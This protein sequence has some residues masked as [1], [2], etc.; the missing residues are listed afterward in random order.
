M[1]KDK[2]YSRI[3]TWF[4]DIMFTVFTQH[5]FIINTKDKILSSMNIITGKFEFK[6]HSLFKGGLTVLSSAKPNNCIA[7]WTRIH[8]LLFKKP[9]SNYLSI[10]IF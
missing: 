8:Y 3:K 1:P 2:P 5:P 10:N 9:S 6:Y 7:M 4:T